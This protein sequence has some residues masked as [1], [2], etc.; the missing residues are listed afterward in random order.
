MGWFAA[1]IPFGDYRFF[2]IYKG[3][4]GERREA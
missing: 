3:K 4:G 1:Q 2:F